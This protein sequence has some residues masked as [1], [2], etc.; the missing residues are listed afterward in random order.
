MRLWHDSWSSIRINWKENVEHKWKSS[1]DCYHDDGID[2]ENCSFV[3]CGRSARHER[4][5]LNK[6]QLGVL[7]LWITP[8]SSTTPK[9]W[10]LC[11]INNFVNKLVVMN[12]RTYG[13]TNGRGWNFRERAS[14]LITVVGWVGGWLQTPLEKKKT[15]ICLGFSTSRWQDVRVSCLDVESHGEQTNSQVKRNTK[16]GILKII[17]MT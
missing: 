4:K 1:K 11:W 8:S 9:S 10:L 6:L 13:R 17:K 16:M 5:L 12:G 15:L 7:L 14:R 2:G 3:N